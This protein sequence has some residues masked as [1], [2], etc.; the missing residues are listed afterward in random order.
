[1]FAGMSVKAIV[2]GIVAVVF[3]GLLF[4]IAALPYETFL[5]GQFGVEGHSL[6]E[7]LDLMHWPAMAFIW[8]GVFVAFCLGGYVAT[9]FAQSTNRSE[10]IATVAI[11]LMIVWGIDLSAT[12]SNI[13]GPIIYSVIAVLAAILGKKLSVR[14]KAVRS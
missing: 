1:M 13:V 7:N 2:L 6:G 5:V 10:W 11:L 4:S 14:S 3:I 8:T 9:R 12:S